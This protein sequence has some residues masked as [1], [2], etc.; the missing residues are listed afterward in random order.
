MS[1]VEGDK[2]SESTAELVKDLSREVSEL[3][4]QEIALA[5]AE[6]VQKGRRA[7]RGAGMLSGAAV[8]GLAAVGGSMATLILL[9]DLVMPAWLAALIVSAAYA[10]VAAVLGRRGKEEISEAGPPAP[11][12]TVESV[13]EDVQWAKT[14]ATSSNR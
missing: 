6:M 8:L 14:R 9:L 4:R 12:Q 7:G 3:V 1:R 10:A 11:E 2:R 13:K 5:R